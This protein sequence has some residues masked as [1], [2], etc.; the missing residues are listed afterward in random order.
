MIKQF[1]DDSIQQIWGEYL[2]SGA[3]PSFQAKIDALAWGKSSNL[4]VLVSD[5]Q[6]KAKYR[7]SVFSNLG[8]AAKKNG[9]SLR[10]AKCGQLLDIVSKSTSTRHSLVDL[11]LTN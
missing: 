8:Y 2:S 3:P 10:N 1:N 4:W 11:R 9:F 5:L 7:F 6:T